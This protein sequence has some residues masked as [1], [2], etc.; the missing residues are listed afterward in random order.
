MMDISNRS[1]TR[2]YCIQLSSATTIILA[3][4]YGVP[5]STTHAQVGA[6]VGCGILELMNP[7]SQLKLKEV[8]NWKLLG[9]T[10]FGWIM[11]L[12]ISGLTSAAI[13]CLLAYSPT[14]RSVCDAQ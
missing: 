2:G 9:Q 1:C 6:T 13:F 8:V 12:L 5:A 11:T 7:D 4:Y 3:S 14:V 10:F